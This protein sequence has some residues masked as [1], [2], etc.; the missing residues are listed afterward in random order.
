MV[1]ERS[2]ELVVSKLRTTDLSRNCYHFLA[3]SL[4]RLTDKLLS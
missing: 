1:W 3:E 2:A 4:V